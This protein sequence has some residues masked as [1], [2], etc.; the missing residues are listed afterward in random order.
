MPQEGLALYA[1]LVRK[2]AEIG[3]KG[4]GTFYRATAKK[5]NSI[6]RRHKAYRGYGSVLAGSLIITDAANLIF[7]LCEKGDLLYRRV[8]LRPS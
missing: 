3:T 8:G 6:K 7:D 5:R 4:L 1:A 2:E